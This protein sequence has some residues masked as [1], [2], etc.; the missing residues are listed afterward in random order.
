MWS[1]GRRRYW[2]HSRVGPQQKGIQKFH[3]ERNLGISGAFSKTN[4][5]IDSRLYV[6]LR[7]RLVIFLRNESYRKIKFLIFTVAK[8]TQRWY[9]LFHIT[10][11]VY[12]IYLNNL[13]YIIDT[14]SECYE[15]NYIITHTA[16]IK[17]DLQCLEHTNTN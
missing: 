1:R 13:K 15:I 7:R 11:N 6:L 5:K 9:S 10:G 16:T 3:S 17:L 2:N 12:Q 14:C 4:Q 8:K